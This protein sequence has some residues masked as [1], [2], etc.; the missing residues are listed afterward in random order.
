MSQN[1]MVYQTIPVITFQ[2]ADN[3]PDVVELPDYKTDLAAAFDLQSA[4]TTS[5]WPK[6]KAIIRTGLR[7]LIPQNFYVRIESRS[8]L[9]AKFSVEKG[10]GI[11]DADYCDE[12][13]VILHNH[14]DTIFH[15]VAGDRI[16]QA[17]VSPCIQAHLEWGKVPKKHP[18]SNRSGGFGSTGV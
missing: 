7:A 8:G 6:S 1:I 13:K 9:S 14:S 16:A 4:E 18:S 11:I 10:A 17:I 2:K 15:I 5:V 12:W 3:C